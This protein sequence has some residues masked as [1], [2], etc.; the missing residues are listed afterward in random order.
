MSAKQAIP[1]SMI[2][3]VEVSR[4]RP[5]W[6]NPRKNEAAVA[7]VAKAIESYGF[8]VPLVVDKDFVIITGHSRYGAAL[9]LGLKEIPVIVSDL[10]Q[11]KARQF[12][13]ADN[14]TAEKSQWD[15]ERLTSELL[16]VSSLKQMVEDFKVQSWEGLVQA[17][18][19]SSIGNGDLDDD[20]TPQPE[21]AENQTEDESEAETIPPPQPIEF[22]VVCP[23]CG[24]KSTLVEGRDC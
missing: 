8:Q 15:F 19:E 22:H 14:K 24:A 21:N 1:P 7:F 4:I 2:Q 6:R 18:T 23:H 11:N 12:R 16:D 3:L 5:Y 9:K 10:S 17:V 13:I 20:D